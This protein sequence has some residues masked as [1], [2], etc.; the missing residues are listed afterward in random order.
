MRVVRTLIDELIQAGRILYE[1]K[2]VDSHSGNLS[3]RD[4]RTVAITRTGARLGYLSYH[5]FVHLDLDDPDARLVEQASR[6]WPVHQAVYR[7][8][9]DV[10]V[11]LHAHPVYLN[12]WAWNVDVFVPDDV[13]G[14]YYIRQ[15]PVIEIHPP[16]ATAALGEALVNALQ[17]AR[18]VLVRHHGAFAAGP[19]VD[20]T[21]KW[22]VAAERS[23]QMKYLHVALQSFLS[24]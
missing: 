15:A 12:V 11:I 6:E 24:G 8:L 23:A 16:T 10:R 17:S 7:S 9:A 20:Q 22:L 19:D 18:V 5:D 14:R 4:G 3:V 13:E 2:L 1:Q 21:L